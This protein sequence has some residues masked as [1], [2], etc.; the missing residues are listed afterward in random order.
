MNKALRNDYLLLVTTL[1]S[2]GG[3]FLFEVSDLHLGAVLSWAVGAAVGLALSVV[4]LIRAIRD[5][6]FGSD[7]LALVS[8]LATSLTG[9]W[10]AASVI[11]VM[12]ATGRALERW[13]EGRAR[14]QLEALLA[15]APQF[16]HVIF[17]DGSIKDVALA[18]VKVGDKLLVRSGEVV[19]LDGNLITEG[20]FDESALTGEPLPQY[21]AATEEVSSGVLN[22]AGEVEMIASRDAENSTYSNLIRLVQQAQANTANGVRIANRWA[23][24]FVPFAL[25]LSVGTWIFTGELSRAVA[26]I[27]AAT[28][29]PLILAVPVA[30]IAGM[31]KAASRGA[32]IKGGAALEQLARTETVMLDKTGTLTHGGPE[33]TRIAFAPDTDESEIIRLAASLEQ[34]SPHV[35]AQALIAEAKRR[36]LSLERASEVIENHGVGLIGKVAGHSIRVGQPATELPE[37]AQLDNALLVAVEE[38]GELKAMIGLDDPLRDEAKSTVDWLRKLGVKRVIM[39]S[40]DRKITAEAVGFEVGVDE[41]FAECKPE[42]KLAIVKAEMAA[43]KGSVVVVGD[44][45]N[46]APALAASDVG[47]AMGARGSTA[48]SEAADVVIVEDSIQH[49][50][51]AMQIAKGTRARALQAAGVGMSFAMIAMLAASAGFINSTQSAVSQEFIDMAAILWALVPVKYQM[52]KRGN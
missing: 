43:A 37:W 45:I 20:S 39:V 26:V 15:R 21:H 38:D 24:R 9:E 47:V 49:L 22:A 29:C 35:I 40:G 19:P 27:V 7:M 41:V 4:L 11:S 1:A 6:E 33:I 3:G 51:V 5:K 42:Q 36:S 17:A 31:S 28:P 52:N 13:A 30:I 48:A 44:G 8:I 46:D 10:I 32:I 18:S 23:V 12:L 50:A 16:A 34:S 14:R 25:L 2:L